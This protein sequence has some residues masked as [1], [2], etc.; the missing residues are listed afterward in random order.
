MLR[1][2]SLIIEILLSI[3]LSPP[4]IKQNFKSISRNGVT[5]QQELQ[6]EFQVITKD[7]QRKWV[8]GYGEYSPGKEGASPALEGILFDITEK[9]KIE[10]EKEFLNTHDSLTRLFNRSYSL[11]TR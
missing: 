8:F 2:N 4:N 6:R 9:K 1:K 3:L 5:E 7:N 10:T 11:N